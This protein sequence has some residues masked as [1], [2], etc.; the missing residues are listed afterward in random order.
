MN[1][2]YKDFKKKL[3]EINETVQKRVGHYINSINI[4]FKFVGD[5]L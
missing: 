4:L 1:L 2:D 3:D 5:F